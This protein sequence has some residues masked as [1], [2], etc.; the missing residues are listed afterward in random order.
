MQELTLDEMG[1]VSGGD[2]PVCS[3]SGS[4]VTCSCPSGQSPFVLSQPGGGVK[5]VCVQKPAS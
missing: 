3:G 5:I 1:L 2:N 4:S